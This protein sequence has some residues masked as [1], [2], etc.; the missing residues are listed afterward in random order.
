MCRLFNRNRLWERAQAGELGYSIRNWKKEKPK[1][2]NA[3]YE[4]THTELL[5][6]WDDTYPEGDPRRHVGAEINRHVDADGNVGFSGLWDPSKGD[7]YID[8]VR[9]RLY[10]TKGGR[11][12]SCELCEAGDMIPCEERQRDSVYRPGCDDEINGN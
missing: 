8:G 3:G 5:T 1:I 10:K 2:D 6:L 12:P 9:Y 4:W 7:L 11:Q